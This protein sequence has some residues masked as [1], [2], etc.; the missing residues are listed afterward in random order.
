[1]NDSDSR[2]QTPMM[3][4][5]HRFGL[6]VLLSL[7]AIGG[8]VGLAGLLLTGHLVSLPAW[9]TDRVEARLSLALTPVRVDLGRVGIV[10][11]PDGVP[12]IEARDVVVFD[13]AGRDVVR[14]PEIEAV[15]S[16][17]A[18]LEGRPAISHVAVT[19]AD[20]TLR[21]APDGRLDLALGAAVRPTRTATGVAETLDGIDR[22]FSKPFLA[23]V[24][25]V[26]VQALRL[27]Y[28]D[29]FS[30]RVWRVEDGLMTLDQTETE[31]ALQAFF[32]LHGAA[33]RPSEFAFNF[34]SVRGG[35]EARFAASF[36]DV[37]A[38]DLATQSP[39]LAP[40]ALIDAP[41]SGAVRTEVNAAGELGP[42]SAALES[43]AGV[44]KPR[45]GA[46]PIRFNAAKSYFSYDPGARRLS[47]DQV[48]LDS[49]VLRFRAEGHAYLRD[50]VG[51][52]PETLVSQLAFQELTVDPD[53]VFE[54]PA[55]FT[56][57]ALD[58][59]LQLDPL[60][61]TIGQVVLTDATRSYRGRGRVRALA[62]GWEV[63]VDAM[64]EEITEDRLLALWPL[65]VAPKP[66]NWFAEH[67]S[68]GEIRDAR[69]AIRLSPGA[70][71]RISLTHAFRDVEV[72]V[73]E[74]M[75]PVEAARGYTTLD[76]SRYTV[77]IEGGTVTAPDGGS[78]DLTGTVLQ[79][80]DVDLPDAPAEIALKATG[81][82]GSLLSLI[83]LPPL[84][85]PAKASFGP[86]IAQGRA[87]IEAL[88]KLPLKRDLAL[89]EIDYA[90]S[91]RLRDVASD[92]LVP[93]RRLTSAA[94][95]L[96]VTPG[97]IAVAGPA[98]LDGVP[99]TAEW[100]MA[101]G[102]TSDG[103]SRV[104]GRAELSAL[105]NTAFGLGLPE[106]SL[107]GAAEASF[108]L[109][110]GQGVPPRLR[111]RSDLAG[112]G[113]RL[114][115]LGWSKPQ[116]AT[117]AL[118]VDATLSTPPQ[119]DRL[120]LSAPG[121]SATGAVS[122]RPGGELEALRLDRLRL[123]DW[124]DAAVTLRG[125]GPGQPLAVSIGGGT[126]DLERKPQT[127]A[128]GGGVGI[129]R[130]DVALDRLR[131]NDA[132]ALTGLRGQL[133]AA[134][135]LA[136]D[137]TG[138]VAGGGP[139]SVTL[140]PAAAGPAVRVRSNDAGA[141]LRGAGLYK[142]AKGGRL[143]LLLTP[144]EGAGRYDGQLRIIDLRVGG[145]PW[146]VEML[147][148]ISLVGMI[149]LMDGDGLAFTDIQSRFGLRPGVVEIRQGSAVGPSLG[150]SVSGVYLTGN[151][152]IELRGVVSPIYM[153]NSIGSAI[154]RRGEG[155]FGFNY[156]VSGTAD[157]P[158]VGVNPL[159]ILM[160][161]NLREIFRGPAPKVV[162]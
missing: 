116:G 28:E 135:G 40:L 32:S 26:S 31:V 73:L 84:R 14:L 136:G 83:D 44:L 124:L 89:D 82:I 115:G 4:P 77:S 104:E 161:G 119:V 151:K 52:W 51:G 62:E 86:D 143:D 53:G 131:V 19:G 128:G 149:E 43:G 64:L 95:S 33:A 87:E 70:P 39:A 105:T 24:K 21:R 123:G 102:E 72:N 18:L 93:G 80:P 27:T 6:W 144:E 23:A 30:G 11:S 48:S 29:A 81:G 60:V 110:M 88:L 5:H 58:L 42:L 79:V 103:A 111:L 9:A 130:I 13:A 75:P 25:S 17:R 150:V 10:I 137:L 162:E 67:V 66:R 122:L 112:L 7:A 101:L 98:R 36:S 61:A 109:D 74:T 34:V 129:G 106:D 22:A 160:P 35:P 50:L 46:R 100:T 15:V 37:P 146:L 125:Q 78:I 76:G 107:T 69:A 20:L 156:T 158:K 41:I 49:P 12:H 139:V 59:K 142:E 108:T 157:V 148:A 138:R 99:L 68:A 97:T 63:S 1:M 91:G 132:I 85:I 3:A 145:T 134:R 147:H 90:V 38:A 8:M 92:M 133:D 159:S 140:S 54:R 114:S 155:L 55:A 154:S 71:P 121:L 57:G 2:I 118:E 96:T 152:R 141:V 113:M 94:V 127:G 117:G 56:G 120:A 45:G 16:P 153:L 47:F 126:V 65:D